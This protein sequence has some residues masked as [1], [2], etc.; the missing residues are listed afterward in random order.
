MT[1]LQPCIVL[2]FLLFAFLIPVSFG[3]E[4]EN[5][6]PLAPSLCP[7]DRGEEIEDVEGKW[8]IQILA[9]RVTAEGFMLHFQYK[10]IDPEKSMMLLDRRVKPYLINQKN[11]AKVPVLTSRFG[12]LRHTSVKPAANRNYAILFSNMNKSVKQGDKVT[13]VI[14]DFR[15]ENL[16]VQ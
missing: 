7:E 5:Q 6:Q 4:K 9:V 3:E 11:G 1:R 8:G 16:A 2:L 12:P 14:G 13:V 15:A 10:V